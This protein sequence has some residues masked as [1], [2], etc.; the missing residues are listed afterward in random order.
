MHLPHHMGGF[1]LQAI[2]IE[3]G[4]EVLSIIISS[5]ASKLPTSKLFKYL[6]EYAQLE[7]RLYES[8]FLNDFNK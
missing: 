4:I 8:I 7:A 1:A 3:Q 2:E 5:F 6:L